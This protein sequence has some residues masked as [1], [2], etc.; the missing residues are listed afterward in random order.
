[1]NAKILRTY[2]YIT[3]SS[4]SPD[5]R[6]IVSLNDKPV[7]GHK[8]SEG[9]KQKRGEGYVKWGEKHGQSYQAATAFVQFGIPVVSNK[10]SRRARLRYN[11]LA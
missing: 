10:L 8:L 4:F 2:I 11:E 9:L 3:G 7:N 1:M 5:N 6:F